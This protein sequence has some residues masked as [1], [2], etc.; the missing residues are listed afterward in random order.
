MGPNDSNVPSWCSDA[1]HH[2]FVAS[3]DRKAQVGTAE[4]A[5]VPTREDAVEYRY[6]GADRMAR[7]GTSKRQWD[8]QGEFFV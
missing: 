7:L 6:K 3:M 2:N 5:F 8:P 4:D 1:A